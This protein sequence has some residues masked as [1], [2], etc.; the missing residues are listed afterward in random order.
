MEVSFSP[1][2]AR[3]KSFRLEFFDRYIE[4]DRVTIDGKDSSDT[5]RTVIDMTT[6]AEISRSDG[7]EVTPV[8]RYL[9]KVYDTSSFI[10]E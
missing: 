5:P 4:W 8:E 7:I 6:T 2:D 9:K 1:A 10:L 3:E